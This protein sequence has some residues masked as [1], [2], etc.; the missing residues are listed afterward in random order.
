MQTYTL[1]SIA[2]A[3]LLSLVA[4][5]NE[6]PNKLI[7]GKTKRKLFPLLQKSVVVF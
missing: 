1:K 6:K 7:E 2:I 4:C 3:S 5:K